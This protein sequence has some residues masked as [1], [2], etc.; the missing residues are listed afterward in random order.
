MS[1]NPLDSWGMSQV[2]LETWGLIGQK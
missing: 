2:P 1:Q